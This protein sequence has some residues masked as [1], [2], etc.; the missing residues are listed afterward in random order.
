MRKIKTKQKIQIQSHNFFGF[1][2]YSICSIVIIIII[3]I[4]IEDHY[5]RMATNIIQMKST[6]KNPKYHLN[7]QMNNVYCIFVYDNLTKMQDRFFNHINNNNKIVNSNKT[8]KNIVFLCCHH[9]H[10]YLEKETYSLMEIFLFKL[11]FCFVSIII[12]NDV[13]VNK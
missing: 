2:V 12:R 10:H 13:E 5:D 1:G 11:C 3:I 8:K 4:T 6:K 9:H 7:K